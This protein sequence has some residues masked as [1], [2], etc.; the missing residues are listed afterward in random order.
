MTPTTTNEQYYDERRG[1]LRM[2]EFSPPFRGF[3]WIDWF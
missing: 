3:Q 1:V 2:E